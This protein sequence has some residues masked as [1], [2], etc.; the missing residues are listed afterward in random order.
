MTRQLAELDK[1]KAEFISV[2]SHE[3]KTPMNVIIGY[4]ELLK[5]GIYGPLSPKQIEIAA[6]IEK[7]AQTL[8]RLVRQLLDV[9]RFE[10][11]G[12]RVEPRTVIWRGFLHHL[13]AAF[14]GSA[15]AAR[16]AFRVQRVRDAAPGSH[17]G[18]GSHQRGARQPAIERVQVHRPGRGGHAG[19]GQRRVRRHNY[20]S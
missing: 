3:L 6:T 8:T 16:I 17:L 18:R 7:Q 5:E 14:Q 4:L 1:L 20:H 15:R 19:R 12:G 11:G 10:A 2:A 13:E 9:S